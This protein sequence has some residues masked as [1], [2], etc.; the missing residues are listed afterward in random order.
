MNPEVEIDGKP[1]MDFRQKSSWTR[2]LERN[3]DKSLGVWVRLG[4]KGSG[5]KTVSREEALDAA[6]C[7][8]W[9]DGQSR[10]EGE[11]TWLQKFTPRTKRSIWSKINREKVQTLIDN[12]EMRPAG[13]AEID[14][15]KQDGRWDA[16]YDS[17]KTIEVPG[18]LMAELKKNPTAKAFFETLDSRNRY[19]ILFRIHTA[20][21]SETRARRI[22]QF[23]EMLTR[24]ERSIEVDPELLNRARKY[25]KPFC[26]GNFVI[27]S[28]G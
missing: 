12:G 16:A 2:W 18:D 14:R 10:S 17:P 15:A 21:K 8:G 3:H 25:E 1:V 6:L 4:K 22:D 23:L 11:A 19:A 7:Y 5:L 13:L 27:L 28:I 24:G 26:D 20:K 9:I